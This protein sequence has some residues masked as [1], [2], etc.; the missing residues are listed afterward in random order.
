MV[1]AEIV[2]AD[3]RHLRWHEV[4]KAVTDLVDALVVDGEQIRLTAIEQVESDAV[5]GL[6]RGQDLRQVVDRLLVGFRWILGGVAPRGVEL[7]PV[8][9]DEALHALVADLRSR[10]HSGAD[11]PPEGLRIGQ[12]LALRRVVD[13]EQ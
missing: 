4:R 8:D 10:D 12:P 7:A 11:L 2:L 13:L 3:H 6:G 5:V 1:L 9:V